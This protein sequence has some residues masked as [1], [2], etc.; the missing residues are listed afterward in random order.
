MSMAVWVLG[1]DGDYAY[2]VAKRASVWL[3]QKIL[4][5]S[6]GS[7]PA[8]FL[9]DSHVNTFLAFTANSQNDSRCHLSRCFPHLVSEWNKG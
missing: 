6:P 1:P 8:Y 9:Y 4:F 5:C 2:A 3:P 7:M